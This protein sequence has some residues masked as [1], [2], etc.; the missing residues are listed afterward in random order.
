MSK[1]VT[2]TYNGQTT[3]YANPADA[4]TVMIA[5]M[6]NT[7]DEG[8]YYAMQEARR[9]LS[10]DN[11]YAA[12]G[13]FD[14]H[15]REIHKYEGYPYRLLKGFYEDWTGAKVDKTEAEFT[16]YKEGMAD[17]AFYARQNLNETLNSN[18]IN[19]EELYN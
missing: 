5:Y 10:V 16:A 18:G 15:M 17:L 3:T 8:D 4:I 13:E 1:T 9:A 12:I 7:E 14:Q 2:I 6:K 19:V 11:V